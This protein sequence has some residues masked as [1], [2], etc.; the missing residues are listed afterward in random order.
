[1]FQSIKKKGSLS[2][3]HVDFKKI[4]GKRHVGYYFEL[5]LFTSQHITENRETSLVANRLGSRVAACDLTA[6]VSG[7]HPSGMI[8]RPLIPTPVHDFCPLERDRSTGRGLEKP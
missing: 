3:L 1:M 6:N 2:D 8:E 7:L 5:S 4:V